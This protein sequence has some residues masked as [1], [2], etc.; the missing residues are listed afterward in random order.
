[1]WKGLRSRRISA[2]VAVAV[3]LVVAGGALAYYTA[4]GS[5]GGSASVASGAELAIDAVTPTGKLLSPGQTGEVDATISNPSPF[6][7]R[8]NSLVLGA[9][10][11]TVD[12]AHAGCDTSALQYTRQDNNGEGWEVP[13]RAGAVDGSLA[14]QL[15]GALTM[16]RSAADACQ[17]AIFT[18]HLASGP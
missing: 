9:G 11:I 4:A 3:G 7:V 6:P 5:G 2:A 15:S 13:A 17:D 10:G 16:D 18:V 14:V 12:D 8:V 1:M